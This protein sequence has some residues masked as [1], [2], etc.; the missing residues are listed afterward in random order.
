MY[1]SEGFFVAVY[2]YQ[3][4]RFANSSIPKQKRSHGVN[5]VCDGSPSRMRRVRRISLGMTTRPRS[6]IRRTIPV[7]F[8]RRMSPFVCFYAPRVCRHLHSIH[9]GIWYS[10]LDDTSSAKNA[11]ALFDSGGILRGIGEPAQRALDSLPFVWYHV[12]CRAGGCPANHDQTD[13]KRISRLLKTCEALWERKGIH[14]NLHNGYRKIDRPH[15]GSPVKKPAVLFI[16]F[17]DIR[18][19]ARL[20]FPT[21][22][23][24]GI[25]FAR[26]VKHWKNL[27]FPARFLFF[28]YKGY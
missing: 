15:T 8:I 14:R 13:P 20:S 23:F 3:P 24:D 12:K 11:G 19:D 1:R 27:V 9:G 18:Y 22:S 6:S 17:S 26:F 4:R 7:A 16:R 28:F 2:S 25:R 5:A 10:G 21:G